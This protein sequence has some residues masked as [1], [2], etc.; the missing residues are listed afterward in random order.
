VF[1]DMQESANKFLLPMTAKYYLAPD[2]H[3]ELLFLSDHA[4]ELVLKSAK[5]GHRHRVAQQ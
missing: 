2:E 3:G 4:K 5:E 1:I